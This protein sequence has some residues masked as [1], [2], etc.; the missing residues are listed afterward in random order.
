MSAPTNVQP[1]NARIVPEDGDDTLYEVV[2]GRRV[3]KPPLG[4]YECGIASL[5]HYYLQHFAKTTGVGRARMETMFRIDPTRG[6]E[7]R[8]D[9]A[10]VSYQRWPKNR[11]MGP[12]NAWEVIPELATEVISPT[13]SAAEVAIKINEYFRA[14]V[15]LVWVVY[16]ILGQVYVYTAATQ[17]HILERQDELDGGNALPGFRLPVAAL[18]EDEFEEEV[19]GA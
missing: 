14:G 6:L 9:V 1:A 2:N 19:S 4:F 18:F 16:P 10:F 15:Q 17:V 12:G 13:N 5:L 3:E 7:R 11:K 8:P